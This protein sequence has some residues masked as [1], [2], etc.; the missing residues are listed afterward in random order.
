MNIIDSFTYN[1]TDKY[2]IIFIDGSEKD[3]LEMMNK[4]PRCFSLTDYN[5]YSKP[6]KLV[7][8]VDDTGDYI[9][10]YVYTPAELIEL[11]N[12]DLEEVLRSM[13]ILMNGIMG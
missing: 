12:N 4:F 10:Y 5:K 9:N 11:L 1:E 13:K 2:H 7:I 3:F 8:S 6:Q